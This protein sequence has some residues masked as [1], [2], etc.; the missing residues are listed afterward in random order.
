[1]MQL[2]RVVIAVD[3]SPESFGIARW[4]LK[5]FI[6]GVE[7]VFIHVVESRGNDVSR[8]ATASLE[9][10][11]IGAQ[12]RLQALAESL[13]V[14]ER[15]VVKVGDAAE[16]I[17]TA[18]ATWG[19]QLVVIGAHD[20]RS[21]VHS[22]HGIAER[23]VELSRVSVLVVQHEHNGVPSAPP[24]SAL[25]PLENTD[26]IPEGVGEWV[27]WLHSRTRL[28]FEV[29]HAVA[30]A[31]PL[32]ALVP[33][34]AVP[35]DFSI[36]PPGLDESGSLDAFRHLG[37]PDS[38]VRFVSVWGDPAQEII[39]TTERLACDLII[40][41]ESHHGRLARTLF[42][43]VAKSVAGAAPCPVLIVPQRPSPS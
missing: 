26:V 43:S 24:A 2:R 22:R 16:A 7:P 32:D 39:A 17:A 19:A 42:G 1:M 28:R 5:Q 38:D 10:A 40:V 11:C 31:I 15:C 36:S 35:D 20:G 30:P 29:L 13:G 37:I 25:V 6:P 34:P 27:Q 18:T 21:R 12:R 23:I 8:G 33:V 9:T 41:G 3:L 14:E 4:T